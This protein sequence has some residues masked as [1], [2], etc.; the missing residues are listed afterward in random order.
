V[1]NNFVAMLKVKIRIKILG[2]LKYKLNL[3]KIKKWKTSF[4][5][6]TAIETLEALPDSINKEDWSYSD[7]QL[8]NII[9]DTS[10]SQATV[11][12][13]SHKLTNNYYG[14]RITNNCYVLSLYQTAKIVFSNDLKLEDFIIQNLYYVAALYYRYKGKIPTSETIVTHQ[15]IRGCL[16]DF[17][18]NKKDLVFSLAKVSI[19]DKCKADFDSTIVP[20]NFVANIKT[21]L[22]RIKKSRY[23]VIR[24]FIR[25]RPICSI[26]LGVVLA[27]ILNLLSSY[28]FS[29]CAHIRDSEKTITEVKINASNK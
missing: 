8:K 21:E 29:K 20:E 2:G 16:F 14:R 1:A 10:T 15:D 9:G 6:I 4:Y 22:S 3:D 27:V 25:R 24:D 7:E 11:A 12:I 19:C 23:F 17:N 5:E 13:I 26:L 28:I 18:V